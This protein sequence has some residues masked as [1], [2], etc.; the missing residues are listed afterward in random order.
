MLIYQYPLCSTSSLVSNNSRTE[1]LS[2]LF[3]TCANSLG[4]NEEVDCLG[5]YCQ[6]Y[7]DGDKF[8]VQLNTN[9]YQTELTGYVTDLDNNVISNVLD[10]VWTSLLTEYGAFINVELDM[11]M[12]NLLAGQDCFK[13][14]IKTRDIND[15]TSIWYSV[16]F[17]RLNCDEPSVLICSDYTKRDCNNT[18]YSYSVIHNASSI[19]AVV[20]SNCFRLK[21]VLEKRSVAIENT[22]DELETSLST[23]VVHTKSKS[24]DQYEL[25]IWGIPDWQVDRLK[26]V[27]GGTTLTI[28]QNNRTYTLEV[29]SG[30]EKNTE[31][32]NLWYPVIKLE[33]SCQKTL[34]SC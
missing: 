10:I 25:R 28:K 2:L 24:I 14:Y 34:K 4:F 19:P 22:Y 18:I 13:V 17:C 30:L 8:I 9:V 33:K 16:P 27:L 3:G 29:K 5:C 31:I 26:A 7:I 20:Y 11:D 15:N 23:R 21:G 32:G 6:P 12:L 1:R